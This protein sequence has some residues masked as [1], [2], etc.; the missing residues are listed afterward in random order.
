MISGGTPCSPPYSVERLGE[1]NDR[2]CA[3]RLQPRNS[4]SVA[5]L[6][7]RWLDRGSE[8]SSWVHGNTF[9]RRCSAEETVIRNQLFDL[10]PARIC[11]IMPPQRAVSVKVTEQNKWSWQLTD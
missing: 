2:C 9:S 1:G 8:M 11:N 10:S 4:T 3:D 5:E 7:N 6:A